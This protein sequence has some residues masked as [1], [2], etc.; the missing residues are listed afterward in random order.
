M[1]SFG[2]FSL[3]WNLHERKGFKKVEV[4]SDNKQA[5]QLINS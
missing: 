2:Q 5:V 4:G 1:Q 3:A